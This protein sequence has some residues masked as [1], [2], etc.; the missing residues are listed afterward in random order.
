[1][2]FSNKIIQLEHR[3]NQI[4]DDFKDFTDGVRVLLLLQRTKDGGA[5]DEEKRAFET[6]T[7]YSPEEFKE[8]LFNLLLIKST[9]KDNVRIYLSANPRN[10]K[11]VI[12]YTEQQLLDAHYSSE[13]MQNSVYKKLLKKP[14][15]FLMQQSC[16]DGSLFLID[17]DDLDGKDT[18]DIAIKKIAE[19]GIEEVKRYRTKNGWHFV[20]KPFNLALW[21]CHGEVKKDPLILLD[22]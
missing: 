2:S 13:E 8:K 22:Y 10:I 1:M 5:N 9:I 12:R 3:T 4:F 21:D 16:K 11:K 14:R 15:H 18:S 7:T 19:L 6:Y 20:V 17:V